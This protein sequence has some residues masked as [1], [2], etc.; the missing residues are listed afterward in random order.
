MTEIRE[1]RDT[2]RN[3]SFVSLY[4]YLKQQELGGVKSRCPE[5]YLPSAPI[6]LRLCIITCCLKACVSEGS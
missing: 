1:E 6:D 3:I 5:F 2:E 4:K